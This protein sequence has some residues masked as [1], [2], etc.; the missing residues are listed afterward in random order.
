M[1]NILKESLCNRFGASIDMPGNAIELCPEGPMHSNKKIF[2]TI[3]HEENLN[4]R[5]IEAPEQKGE[6]Q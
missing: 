4:K 5:F 1:I 6:K 3:C 2:Y